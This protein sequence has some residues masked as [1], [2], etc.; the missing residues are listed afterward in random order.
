MLAPHF[1]IDWDQAEIK[2]GSGE[3]WIPAS[4]E[5]GPCTIALTSKAW[6]AAD[7]AA[8]NEKR[9]SGEE[10]TA[11][12]I[13]DRHARF[14]VWRKEMPEDRVLWLPTSLFE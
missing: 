2:R 13:I 11:E 10:V 3:R 12:D 6:Y 8:Y 7:M 14:K 1:R 9:R 4:D 5:D